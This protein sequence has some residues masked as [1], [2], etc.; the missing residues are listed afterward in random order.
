MRSRSPRLLVIVALATAALIGAVLLIV[1]AAT[2]GSSPQRPVATGS[3]PAAGTTPA[4][5]GPAV[6]ASSTAPAALD[7][8]E[9]EL[10]DRLS[11][12]E[13]TDCRSATGEAGGTGGAG[14]ATDVRARGVTAALRCT[15]GVA[16]AGRPPAEVV[17]LGYAD[18]AAM[19]ADAAR[20][21][22]AVV[23]VGSCENGQTSSEAY[24]LPSRRT[25]TFVCDARPGDF[26]A[27]WTIDREQAGFIAGSDDPTGL[28][29]WWRA[30]DPL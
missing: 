22:S 9:Q 10:R 24:L 5:P 26:T 16:G 15:P 30:F 8:A 12:F 4:A 25:G 20:R 27:Y 23:D 11:S 21:S 17:V 1:L 2:R 28:L 19:A 7:D 14:G 18:S 13:L 29:T 6:T 3:P